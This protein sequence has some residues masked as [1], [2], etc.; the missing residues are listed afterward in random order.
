MLLMSFMPSNAT[1]PGGIADIS[2]FEYTVNSI[3]KRTQAILSGKAITD[4]GTVN[5]AGD[6]GAQ[7]L[8][9]TWG[10]TYNAQGE[11]ATATGTS[12]NTAVATINRSFT[13]DAIGN[14]TAS[15]DGSTSTSYES[16]ALNQYE[17]I[18]KTLANSTT[19]TENKNHDA[20]GNTTQDAD[21]KYIFDAEDR[22]TEVTN[23]TGTILVSYRYDAYSRRIERSVPG[24]G[25][26]QFHYN[27]WN[28]IA[29]YTHASGTPT[30][31]G[32]QLTTTRTWGLDISGTEQGAGGIGGLLQGVN[33]SYNLEL[34]EL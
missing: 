21:K 30:L 28:V 6:E 7:A 18:T 11:L 12:D 29:E 16:N 10:Y 24:T 8:P 15:N 17:S 32:W 13:F 22:L 4:N 3:G 23:L 1:A 2:K 33:K 9:L 27:S 25:I 19:V 5:T 20:D 14:R 26:T 31:T 34:T